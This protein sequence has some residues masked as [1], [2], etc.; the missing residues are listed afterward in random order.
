MEKYAACPHGGVLVIIKTLNT[1]NRT[2][3]LTE[4]VTGEYA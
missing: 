4:S 3:A 1:C 2:N